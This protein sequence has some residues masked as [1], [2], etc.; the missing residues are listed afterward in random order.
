MRTINLRC[1]KKNWVK[2]VFTKPAGR[3]FIYGMEATAWAGEQT[4]YRAFG[5]SSDWQKH[6]RNTIGG[7]RSMTLEGWAEHRLEMGESNTSFSGRWCYGGQQKREKKLGMMLR[8]SLR[9]FCFAGLGSFIYLFLFS[10]FTISFHRLF[11]CCFLNLFFYFFIFL[12]FLLDT[13]PLSKQK[14]PDWLTQKVRIL[15]QHFFFLECLV[16][17]S[18]CASICPVLSKLVAA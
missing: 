17:S 8:E 5:V 13:F 11:F 15:F 10:V 2:Q 4:F 12:F 9:K 6:F 18:L 14:H 3:K 16:S 1:Q 7:Q